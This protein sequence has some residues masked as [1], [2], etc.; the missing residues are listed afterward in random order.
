MVIPILA[1]RHLYIEGL[2]SHIEATFV[3]AVN[4]YESWYKITL[5]ISFTDFKANL[6]NDF[7]EN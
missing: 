3:I 4:K 6:Q 5:V 1:M 2:P 7:T